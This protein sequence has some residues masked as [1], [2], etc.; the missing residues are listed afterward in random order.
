[1]TVFDGR[2]FTEYRRTDIYFE[3]LMKDFSI[4]HDNLLFKG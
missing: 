3:A 2:F 4:I 1:M